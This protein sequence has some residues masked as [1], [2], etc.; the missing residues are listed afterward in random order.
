[1]VKIAGLILRGVGIRRIAID[2]AV[3]WYVEFPI[4]TALEYHVL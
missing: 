1:M 4:R 2:D 3:I